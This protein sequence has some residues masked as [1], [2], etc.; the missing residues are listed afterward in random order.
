M[1]VSSKFNSTSDVCWYHQL[2]KGMKIEMYFFILCVT[3]TSN[4]SYMRRKKYST[5]QFPRKKY[6][7]TMTSIFLLFHF[8]F[9]KS[10]CFFS[11]YWVSESKLL[12]SGENILRWSI[13]WLFVSCLRYLSHPTFTQGV[14]GVFGRE[15]L[16]GAW[17]S[18]P[19]SGTSQIRK[20]ASFV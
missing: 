20:I 7:T 1:S 15:G 6:A 3:G 11:L 16:V 12:I 17:V 19:K 9:V 8:K 5:F 14:K 13:F 2:D 18:F 4:K 10:I